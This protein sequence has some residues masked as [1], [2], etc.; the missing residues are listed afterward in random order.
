[1]PPINPPTAAP[2]RDSRETIARLRRERHEVSTARMT[3]FMFIVQLDVCI[4]IV[5]SGTLARFRGFANPGHR[6]GSIERN[7]Q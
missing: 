5:F 6:S 1:M 2:P 3:F 7:I 4:K